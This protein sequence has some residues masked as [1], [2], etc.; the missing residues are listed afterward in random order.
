MVVKHLQRVDFHYTC[1]RFIR[2]LIKSPQSNLFRG[3]Y[4][5][6]IP[7]LIAKRFNLTKRF[8]YCKWATLSKSELSEVTVNVADGCCRCVVVTLDSET[9]EIIT[10]QRGSARQCCKGHVSFLWEKPIFDPSQNPNPLTYNHKN[11]HD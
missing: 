2:R 6:N 4:Y 7:E 8:N 11:S 10:C 5:G 3:T 1:D 9:F